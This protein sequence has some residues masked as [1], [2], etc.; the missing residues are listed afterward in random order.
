MAEISNVSRHPEHVSALLKIVQDTTSLFE[1]TEIRGSM[2]NATGELDVHFYNM[3]VSLSD[4][5]VGDS[6]AL[7]EKSAERGDLRGHEEIEEG[8]Q[9]F[10]RC[11]QMLLRHVFRSETKESASRQDPREEVYRINSWKQMFNSLARLLLLIMKAEL[12]LCQQCLSSQCCCL[13]DAD[14]ASAKF[15][16][17]QIHTHRA[18]MWGWNRSRQEMLDTVKVDNRAVQVLCK[19]RA[20]RVIDRVNTSIQMGERVLAELWRSDDDEDDTDDDNNDEDVKKQE[21]ETR[22]SL[23]LKQQVTVA[24]QCMRGAVDQLHT[25]YVAQKEKKASVE[26]D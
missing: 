6:F 21:Y 26:V 15:T 12:R 4:A 19:L 14:V 18:D 11:S 1:C 8:I 24:L 13:S 2:Q 16:S 25:K 23:Q 5:I 20:T 17:L 7:F 10:I 9:S 22:Y 3:A